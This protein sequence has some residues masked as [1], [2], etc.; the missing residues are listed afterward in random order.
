MAEKV[1]GSTSDKTELTPN[2]ALSQ[3]APERLQPDLAR[4]HPRPCRQA[5]RRAAPA[6]RVG[7]DWHADS[8]DCWSPCGVRDDESA[9]CGRRA[10]NTGRERGGVRRSASDDGKTSGHKG[11]EA[12]ILR[13]VSP[14]AAQA[15]VITRAAFLR[16]PM[17]LRARP[18][19]L[20]PM[21]YARPR[22]CV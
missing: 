22:P 2:V 5:E 8:F 19:T 17:S 10:R 7:L 13:I 11:P 1:W 16:E 21:R 18:L 4:I 15:S 12:R 14:S 3:R 6:L 20:P 9:L